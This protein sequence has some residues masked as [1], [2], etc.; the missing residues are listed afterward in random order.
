MVPVFLLQDS[1]VT[2][3]RLYRCPDVM[4]LY[5]HH[6]DLGA[7]TV[8][9]AYGILAGEERLRVASVDLV[10]GEAAVVEQLAR[11]ISAAKLRPKVMA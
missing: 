9:I 10:S 1:T 11:L 8:D 6:T 7:D 4:L 5:P 3:A 2:H